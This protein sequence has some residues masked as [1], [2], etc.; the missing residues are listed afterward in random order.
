MNT[1]EEMELKVFEL[2]EGNLSAEEAKA[3]EVLIQRDQHWAR[4]YRLMQLTYLQ[5]AEADKAVFPHPDKLYRTAATRMLIPRR[6]YYWSA[7]AA[8]A[9]LAI[10]FWL[11]EPVPASRQAIASEYLP[12]QSVPM[13]AGH[14][15]APARPATIQKVPVG[16]L[17]PA[18]MPFGEPPRNCVVPFQPD[19][20]EEKM[21]AVAEP[22]PSSLEPRSVRALTMPVQQLQLASPQSVRFIDGKYIPVN[23]RKS[24]YFRLMN[25]GRE[26]LAYISDPS[27]RLERLPRQGKIDRLRLRIE[28]ERIGIIATLIE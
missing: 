16:K 20:D 24:L 4:E 27:I 2:L 1:K 15:A 19:M 22:V 14:S 21:L 18:P 17:K 3:V 7:A 12:T 5:E 6:A 9:L 23:Q 8:V 11:R 10:G 25:Q 28:T 13:P 26:M